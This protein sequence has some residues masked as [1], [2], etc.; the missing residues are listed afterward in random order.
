MPVNKGRM[1]LLSS[2]FVRNALER[3]YHIYL[4]M[5]VAVAFNVLTIR[6]GHHW[7]GDFGLY[8]THAKNIAMG[9]P[10]TE[11]GYVYNPYT[12]LL[13]PVAYPP[14]YPLYLSPLYKIFGL[15]LF[16][17]KLA[18]IFA[19][20]IFLVIFHHYAIRR[21]DSG[22]SRFIVVAAVAFSPWVWLLKDQILPDFLFMMFTYAAILFMDTHNDT[23][24]T[25]QKSVFN[26]VCMGLLVYL[27]Y[28]T[29]SLGLLLIP[30]FIMADLV[31]RR[32][33]SRSTMICV[34]I[35]A[36]LYL[37]QNTYIH[38][39]QS[40]FNSYLGNLSLQE[41][42]SIDSAT[43]D[44]VAAS[45]L[46]AASLKNIIDKTRITVVS[47][48]F[49]YYNVV[50]S[51]WN[52]DISITTERIFYLAMGVLAIVGFAGLVLKQLS[53]GDYFLVLYVIVLLLVPFRQNR[54]IL[55]LVP[56]YFVYIL[57]GVEQINSRLNLSG[58][59]LAAPGRILHACV[60]SVVI[61]TYA[62]QYNAQDFGVM[63]KG[64]EKKESIEMFE[65]VR[66]HTPADSLIVFREPR[67]LTLVT[68]RRSLTY[69]WPEN[70]DELWDYIVGA[71]ATYIVSQK[72]SAGLV[73]GEGYLAEWTAHYTDRLLTVFENND[74]YVYQIGAR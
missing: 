22:F 21:L 55:P 71:G 68:G 27:S 52:N 4:V 44:A 69:H 24:N 43:A 61:F 35:F 40:Y 25:L 42:G 23:K 26:G 7:N 9:L 50:S 19:F 14:V 60:L 47:N 17:M 58:R 37:V 73:P 62:A 20:A 33:I 54:Y 12:P 30:A 56:L 57:R 74:F 28:G 29:R 15:N 66:R 46:S 13:S 49:Y 34:V 16:A 48:L 64:V 41:D 70:P 63:K 51:Y 39:D 8:V 1:Q 36:G 18:G 3:N 31:T 45:V 5:V 6:A 11:T 59:A 65:F 10:Y 2:S 53:S 67:I 32:T 38:A 72:P